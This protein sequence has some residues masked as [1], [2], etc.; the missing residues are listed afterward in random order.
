MKNTL[1]KET[2]NKMN[3]GKDQNKNNYKEGRKAGRND[4]KDMFCF[5]PDPKELIHEYL[6]LE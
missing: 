4:T 1:Y 5:F 2:K 3:P 6:F